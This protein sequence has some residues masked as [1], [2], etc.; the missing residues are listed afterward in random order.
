MVEWV[1]FGVSVKLGVK[2]A[3]ASHKNIV[4]LY[5]HFTD[6]EAMRRSIL[7]YIICV[8]TIFLFLFIYK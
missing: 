3:E 4:S 2:A 5:N 8:G 1:A 6:N 7:R